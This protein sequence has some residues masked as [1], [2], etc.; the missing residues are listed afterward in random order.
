MYYVDTYIKYY[1]VLCFTCYN[2]YNI[3]YENEKP[4]V[5]GYD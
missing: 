5:L 3:N 2:E 4:C 1:R